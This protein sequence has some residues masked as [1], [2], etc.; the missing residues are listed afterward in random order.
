[1]LENQ[2]IIGFLRIFNESLFYWFFD[3][4][5]LFLQLTIFYLFFERNV[6][7][8]SFWSHFLIWYDLN[9]ILI[10]YWKYACKFSH[11]C[12]GGEAF[13]LKVLI[14]KGFFPSSFQQFTIGGAVAVY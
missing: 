11:W 7:F 14:H 4:W 6:F 9:L 12:G 10:V 5:N 13:L 1:M 8:L 3:F 2:Y